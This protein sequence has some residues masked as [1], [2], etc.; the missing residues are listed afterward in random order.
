M[1]N[2]E[3]PEG[4]EIIITVKRGGDAQLTVK[5]VKGRDCKAITA[6]Y[7]R[8]MGMVVSDRP[9]SEMREVPEDDNR[10]RQRR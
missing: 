9:T 7:E 1:A 3:I 6:P 5:G 8:A 4:G 10:H 2:I